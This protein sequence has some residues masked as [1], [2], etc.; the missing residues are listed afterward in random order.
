MFQLLVHLHH[1]NINLLSQFYIAL[2]I[3]TCKARILQGLVHLYHQ[4]PFALMSFS[5]NV[6]LCKFLLALFYQPK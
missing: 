2:F 5:Q 4:I 3:A 6:F 1:H